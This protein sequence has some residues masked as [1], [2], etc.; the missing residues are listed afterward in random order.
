MPPL[1]PKHMRE[2]VRRLKSKGQIPSSK[3]KKITFFQTKASAGLVLKGVQVSDF[4]LHDSLYRCSGLSVLPEFR[5]RFNIF[6]KTLIS[7]TPV[8]HA[9]CF[10]FALTK[11]W[12]F[13]G[14]S[15][16]WN[17]PLASRKR[18]HG[19][20]ASSG[21]GAA[22]REKRFPRELGRF[23]TEVARTQ[24]VSYIWF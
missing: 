20:S 14:H 8:R 15:E 11:Y 5:D 9:A 13:L 21:Q 16:A 7:I 23:R 2:A 22:F 12:D 6:L 10:I 1:Q 17:C 18:A 3:H 4:G 19:P 24:G